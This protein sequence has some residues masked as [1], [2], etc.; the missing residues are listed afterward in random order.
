MKQIGT[1]LIA[2]CASMGA[3]SQESIEAGYKTTFVDNGFWDNWFVGAGVGSTFFVG[4]GSKHVS[5]WSRQQLT[6]VVQVGKWYNPFIGGRLKFQYSSLH[7]FSNRGLTMQHSKYAQ[8]ELDLLWNFSNYWSIYNEHRLYSFIPYVGLGYGYG[9][10]YKIGGAK[11]ASNQRNITFNAGIINKLRLSERVDLDIE[12]SAT[13]LHEKMNHAGYNTYDALYGAVASLV[14]K[15]GKVG[16]DEAVLQDNNLI[17]NLNAEVN[18]L[19]AENLVLKKRPKTCPECPE[20]MPV[21]AKKEDSYVP[22][23]VFFRV[24]S[25]TIDSSQEVGIFNIAEFLKNHPD[26]RVKIV[27]YADRETGTDTY[28]EAL[29]QRRAQNVAKILLEKYHIDAD[30]IDVEWK[31]SSQQ[32]YAEN[33][34]NRVAI[35]LVN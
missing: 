33:D 4:D 9:W 7:D 34:W 13:L 30:R 35:F 12:L 20:V 27:A 14:I 23:V 21:Q 22:N 28:N 25:A 29:S 31:G 18:R 16:F 6:P 26:K 2:L 19:R 11:S 32:P 8:A 3:F 15:L 1:L 17:D 10:D 24:N 5:F